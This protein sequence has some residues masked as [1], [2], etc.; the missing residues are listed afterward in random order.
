MKLNM[1]HEQTEELKK[2]INYTARVQRRNN[3]ILNTLPE[4]VTDKQPNYS[5]FF[6]IVTFLAV[7]E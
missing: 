5:E 7:Y 4:I 3:D 2:F 6:F 1:T